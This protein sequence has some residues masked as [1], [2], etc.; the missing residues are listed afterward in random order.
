MMNRL[1]WILFTLTL[2]VAWAISYK[3]W[4]L[5]GLI[6]IARNQPRIPPRDWA[7]L[8]KLTYVMMGFGPLMSGMIGLAVL[9]RSKA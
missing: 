9:R 2:A 1:R 3:G 5:K 4:E 7:T 8:L 6:E